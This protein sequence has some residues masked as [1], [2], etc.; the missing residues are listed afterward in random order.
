MLKRFN[1]ASWINRRFGAGQRP[2]QIKQI[3]PAPALKQCAHFGAEH[4]VDV[5]ATDRSPGRRIPEREFKRNLDNWPMRLA[6]S[7]V[8]FDNHLE[9]GSRFPYRPHSVS[10]PHA[11]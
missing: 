10:H 1:N 7:Y 5:V 3:A 4:L 11:P 8:G 6:F 2:I 9:S